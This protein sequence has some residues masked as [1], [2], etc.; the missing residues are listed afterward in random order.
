MR[1]MP[2]RGK[3]GLLQGRSDALL[4]AGMP[5]QVAFFCIGKEGQGVQKIVENIP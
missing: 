3:P 1:Q 2:E 4:F 5:S